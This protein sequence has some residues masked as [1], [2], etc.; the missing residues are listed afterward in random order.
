MAGA[1]A[2]AAAAADPIAGIFG[3][4]KEI[5]DEVGDITQ[6][7]LEQLNAIF[8]IDRDIIKV[9]NVHRKGLLVESRTTTDHIRVSLFEV[10]FLG[11]VFGVWQLSRGEDNKLGLSMREALWRAH[12]GPLETGMQAPDFLPS[13]LLDAGWWEQ[14][15]ASHPEPHVPGHSD[16]PADWTV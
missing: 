13:D 11:L 5:I 3:V 14:Y 9:K 10:L 4:L 7:V 16:V 15:R 12:T 1:A 6:A 8:I 2:G